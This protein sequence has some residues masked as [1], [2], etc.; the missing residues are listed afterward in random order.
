MRETKRRSDTLGQLQATL[1]KPWF[2]HLLPFFLRWNSNFQWL[3]LYAALIAG[4]A[5][6]SWNSRPPTLHPS[7]NAVR[8]ESRHWSAPPVSIPWAETWATLRGRVG[9]AVEATLHR[10]HI[11]P[12]TPTRVKES[13]CCGACRMCHIVNHNSVRVAVVTTPF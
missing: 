8:Y 2:L 10:H 3:L 7:Q 11:T 6:G 5:K 13:L 1:I 9:A 4:V 12:E